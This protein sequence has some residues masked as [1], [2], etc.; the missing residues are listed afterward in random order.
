MIALI[1]A[2]LV[3]LAHRRG[4]MAWVFV[5]T[6]GAVLLSVGVLEARY[7]GDHASG[8]AGGTDRYQ[9]LLVMLVQL[10]S[11]A[12]IM[13]G[14]AA[15][16]ADRDSGVLRD[17]VA[18]GQPRLRLFAARV[19]AVLAVV[20]PTAVGAALLLGVLSHVLAAGMPA[21]PA[22]TVLEGAG[23]IALGTGFASLLALGFAALGVGHG[24]GVGVLIGFQLVASPLLLSV[25]F[26]GDARWAVPLGAINRLLP[27]DPGMRA[28]PAELAV[29]VLMSWTGVA[30]A[31]G[32]RHLLRSD[33]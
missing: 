32:A 5:L 8:P 16:A 31:A 9:H 12:A 3:K 6:F 1:R 33:I 21:P 13:V 27:L 25:D 29:V 28:M 7:L 30:L 15:G 24:T 14:S 18:T 19:P 10:G 26:L 22:T 4:T 11:V 23:W 2:D 17:L 20:L